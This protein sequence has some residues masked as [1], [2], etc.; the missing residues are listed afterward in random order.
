MSDYSSIPGEHIP[1]ASSPSA[2]RQGGVTWRAAAISLAITV[3]SVPAIF[4]GE[5]VWG[6]GYWGEVDARRTHIWST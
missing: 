3:L 1:T 6:T 4:Y 5:T 2:P